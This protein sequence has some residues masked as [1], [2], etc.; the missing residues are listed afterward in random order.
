MNLRSLR[1][2]GFDQWIEQIKSWADVST[3]SINPVGPEEAFEASRVA[4]F[5]GPDAGAYT[6]LVRDI[7]VPPALIK[8]LLSSREGEII[9]I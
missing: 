2:F 4:S 9:P 8:L 6:Q 3:N 1:K 5:S 7:N